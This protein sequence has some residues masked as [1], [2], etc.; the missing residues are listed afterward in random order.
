MSNKDKGSLYA[1]GLFL[2]ALGA[3]CFHAYWYFPFIADD[4][5]ISLRYAQRLLAGQGLNWNDGQP[6][7]GYS[8]LLWILLVAGIAALGSDLIDAARFLG[9]LSTAVC[10]ATVLYIL[11]QHRSSIFPALFALAFLSLSGPFAVWSIGGLEQPLL[12]ALLAGSITLFL[13]LLENKYSLRR[14]LYYLS[15]LLGLI[16]LTRPDGP[17]F[18]AAFAAAAL[19]WI[20]PYFSF[21]LR[22]LVFPVFFYCSQLIF[23][24]SYY[25]EWV[26]NTARV[27]ISI[28]IR[29]SGDRV[30]IPGYFFNENNSTYTYLNGNGQLVIPVSSTRPPVCLY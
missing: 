15:F 2:A 23:R 5:L 28:S 10:L 8:N 26:P 20:R 22:L 17:L 25:G 27:K 14:P 13:P 21:V 3:L 9:L 24:L 7:E 29:D 11:F 30:I 18:V 1:A 16:C 6:V 4:G 12:A 19:P